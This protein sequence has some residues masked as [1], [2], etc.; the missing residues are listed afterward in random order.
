MIYV[1]V[2]KVPLLLLLLLNNFELFLVLHEHQLPIGIHLVILRLPSC[3]D[4][5]HLFRSEA[6]D[7]VCVSRGKLLAILGALV[8]DWHVLQVVN[9]GAF[10]D[11]DRAA[12]LENIPN[13]QRMQCTLFPFCTQSQPSPVRRSHVGKVEA[14]PRLLASRP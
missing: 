1:V 14:C 5:L 7:S 4:K 13:S 11:E 3:T 8:D 2:G 10:N 6:V 9:I 12:N